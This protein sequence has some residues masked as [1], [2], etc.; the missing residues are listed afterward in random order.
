MSLIALMFFKKLILL[1]SLIALMFSLHFFY[2]QINE[3]LVVSWIV[4]WGWLKYINLTT[5]RHRQCAAGLLEPLRPRQTLVSQNGITLAPHYALVRSQPAPTW[6]SDHGGLCLGV[7]LW[8]RVVCPLKDLQLAGARD[9][10]SYELDVEAERV[11]A[12]HLHE[13]CPV[14]E[15]AACKQN[16]EYR[17]F[18]VCVCVCVDIDIW[19]L[20]A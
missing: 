2:I 15:D 17:T 3:P 5:Q 14:F 7:Q 9:V 13:A 19:L 16:T 8:W 4:L 20:A 11:L 6:K 10:D 1:M 18:T 12:G